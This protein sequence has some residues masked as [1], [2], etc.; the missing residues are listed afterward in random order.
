MIHTGNIMRGEYNIMAEAAEGVKT[1][2]V[3]KSRWI[4][5]LLESRERGQV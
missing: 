5:G 4:K 2:Q 3:G 1:E